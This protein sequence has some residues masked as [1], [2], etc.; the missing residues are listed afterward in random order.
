MLEFMQIKIEEFENE[1]YDKYI[2]LFPEDEQR[3]WDKIKSSYEKEQEKFYKIMFE[4][5]IVGFF[6]LEKCSDAHP[7][8]IDYF[9]IFK[10]Y[11]NKGFGTETIKKMLQEIA[12]E[13]G[14]CI[15]IEKADENNTNTLRRAK[16][17]ENL[18]FEKIDSEYVL[19]DVCYV[20]YVY[21]PQKIISKENVDKIMFD[22]YLMN[23]GE[24]EVKERCKIIR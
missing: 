1:I 8:Y 24:K 14:L 17:Y 7:Y 21:M 12:N 13:D 9:A 4:N 11:Q 6:M 16:F 18:G 15:E 3:D 5:K 20:P 10:E 19:Y 22:Y 2:T 23:C